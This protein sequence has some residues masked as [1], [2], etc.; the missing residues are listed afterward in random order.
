MSGYGGAALAVKLGGTGDITANR[1]W[2]HPKNTQRV[3]SGIIVGE[4]VYVL[5]ANGMPHCYELA[6]GKEVWR[7]PTRPT[8]LSWSSMVHAQGRLYV[9]TRP[10]ET[11]VFA[12]SPKYQLLARNTLGANEKTNSSLAISNGELFIRTNRH[13]Y[14]VR[15]MK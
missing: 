6:T 8:D 10:A 13:L 14:C 9:L 15:E 4:H 7:A 3:G 12:A 5:E 11:L 2:H 1:L